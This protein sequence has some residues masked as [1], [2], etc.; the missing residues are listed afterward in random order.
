M[1][2]MVALSS[3]PDEPLRRALRSLRSATTT[4]ADELVT[5]DAGF[6]V[7]S[8]ELPD[9]WDLNHVRITRPVSVQELLGLVEE[10]QRGLSFRQVVVEGTAGEGLEAPLRAAGWKVARNLLMALA[11]MPDRPPNP[12]EL[13]EPD[14]ERV[15]ATMRR[16]HL[17]AH[18]DASAEELEM[19]AYYARIEADGLGDRLLGVEGR[20]GELA[21]ITKLRS[22]GGVAQIEDVYTIPEARNRGYARALVCRA[23]VLARAGG[24][25]LIFLTADDD[26]WPQQLYAR[27]GFAPIGRL[28]AFHL[29]L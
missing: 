4:L 20:G 5:I 3:S 7:R 25:D 29:D 1:A 15:V 28:R 22:F 17:E 14:G 8:T 13:I 10:H 2:A 23:I 19:L 27:L 18:P 9:W 26:D 11:G 24:S 6:V 12:V 16:W 21:A